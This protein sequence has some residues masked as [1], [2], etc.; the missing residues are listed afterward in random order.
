MVNE[1]KP[2]LQIVYK[3]IGS[4]IATEYNPK[5]CSPKDEEDITNSIKRF[6]LVDPIIVNTYPKRENI[7]VG[8][9]QRTRIAKNLGYTEMPCVEVYL[10]LEKEKELNIRLSKNTAPIDEAMLAANFSKEMLLEVG[11]REAQLKSFLSDFEK[12][13]NEIDDSNCAY[14]LVPKFSEKY[15]ALIIVSKNSIDTTLP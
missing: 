3:P 5:K 4:L 6:G 2:K 11:F 14:P 9:H 7:I 1:E 8:G 13:F 10:P 15:D 12:K